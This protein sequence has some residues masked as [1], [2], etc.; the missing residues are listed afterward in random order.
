MRAPFIIYAD[1]ETLNIPVEGCACDPGK[2][3]TRQ[4][5][6]QT[7]CSYCYVVMRC[8]GVAKAPV[9]YCG[10][11]A[12]SHFPESLQAELIEINEVFRK[13]AGMIMTADDFQSFTNATDCHICGEVLNQDRVRD[14]CHVTGK[15]RGAT[16]KACNLQLSI[17]SDG[18]YYCRKTEKM[19]KNAQQRFRWSSTIYGAMTGT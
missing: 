1:F 3:C 11:N 4:I 18:E 9:L 16:H 5:A 15:Y 19:K 17:S 10:E 7:P 8:D 12:V 13:P 2:S 6:K 14:H